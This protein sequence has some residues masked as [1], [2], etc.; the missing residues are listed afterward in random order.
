MFSRLFL[1]LVLTVPILWNS[2]A[3]AEKKN[4]FELNNA[5]IPVS[6]VMSGGPPRDGIPALTDPKFL[7]AGEANYLKDKDRVLALI[8]NGHPKAYPIRILDWHEIVN[9]S[10]GNQHFVVTY[11]PLCGTGVVFD[12]N[13]GQ[14]TLYFGVSGLLY[15]SDVL[16]YDRNTETLWSQLMGEAIAGKLIGTKLT[17]LPVFHTTWKDWRARH[18]DTLVISNETG[19]R[20]NYQKSPYKGYKKSKRLYFKVNHKAPADYHPKE[21]VLG[22]EIDGVFKAYPFIEMS[23]QNLRKF[24]DLVNGKALIVHWDEEARSAY[25]TDGA[26]KDLVST[27]GFWFAWFT[28]HP[29]TRVFKAS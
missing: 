2:D 29:D 3:E 28:F 26:G 10:V 7:S 17:Q 14:T 4:G 21:Q 23:E 16:L 8:I 5:S 25:V 6:E 11:C 20:R 22:L 12:T 27:I 9:D 24:N 1:Y 13:V 18:P 15:N 19:F